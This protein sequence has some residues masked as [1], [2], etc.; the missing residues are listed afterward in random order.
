L[1]ASLGRSTSAKELK[2]ITVARRVRPDV[3]WEQGGSTALSEMA[4]VA[5]P[6]GTVGVLSGHNVWRDEIG[7]R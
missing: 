5:T 2:P 6:G 1:A 4:R 3:G 7:P